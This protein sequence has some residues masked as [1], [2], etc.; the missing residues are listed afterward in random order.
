M[1]VACS[2]YAD[3]HH[4]VSYLPFPVIVLTLFMSLC[5][6]YHH[7]LGYVIFQYWAY[8]EMFLIGVLLELWVSLC[9][10]LHEL[11]HASFGQGADLC[12]L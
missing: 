1:S 4:C 12:D 6:V 8:A 10:L 5:N 7:V 3:M 9:I 2:V 11:V